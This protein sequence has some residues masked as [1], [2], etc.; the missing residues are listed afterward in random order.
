MRTFPNRGRRAARA[1]EQ[2]LPLLTMTEESAFTPRPRPCW[3]AGAAEQ[4]ATS[5]TVSHPYDGTEVAD[6]AVPGAEQV[7]RAVAAAAGAAGR[8]AG[9]Q[10]TVRAAALERL[11]GGIRSRAEEIAETITAEH[12]KPMRWAEVEVEQAVRTCT[13]AAGEA[14]YS[15][16]EPRL[17]DADERGGDR[18]ALVR[19]RPRGPVLAI[20]PS[21]FPLHAPA[22]ELAT[23]LA[24]GAPV[25]LKPASATPLS[26]L[27][28]AEILEGADLPTGAF[29]VL[30]VSG[31]DVRTHAGDGRL[32]VVSFTGSAE[33]GLA[34]RT[35]LAGKHV[36]TAT[37]TRCAAIVCGDWADESD[38]DFAAGRIALFGC[39]A[40]GQSPLAVRRVIM[41]ESVAERCTARLLDAVGALRTG[42][43]HD[44]EVE[45]GP[46]VDEASAGSAVERIEEA[47]AAGATLLLGGKRDGATVQPTV[48]AGVPEDVAL[49]RDE[50]FAPIL[51]L[52]TVDSTDAAFGE[53]GR[54]GYLGPAAVFTHELRRALRSGVELGGDGAVV[55]D[56]PASRADQLVFD[57]ARGAGTGRRL[58]R[59]AMRRLTT[60]QV[61]ELPGL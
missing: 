41:H 9:I 26:A 20:T 59:A 23:A 17:L 36:V 11:A 21:A 5:R 22:L 40:A 14:R 51:V 30:P 15:A 45:V 24:V 3:I 27:L 12:G 60:E 42:N 61:T 50:V 52:S 53:T 54:L 46:L 1:A 18:L 7:E 2:G 16:D 44:P 39:C 25:V 55:G 35:S 4:G 43:P 32:P 10:A 13:L 33:V 38:M 58:V 57:G 47:V 31:A 19:R 28:L 37:G 34:L 56:V 6:V 8:L 49:C 48:L 29:S